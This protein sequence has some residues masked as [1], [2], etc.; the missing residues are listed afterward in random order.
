MREMSVLTQRI[1]GVNSTER[2]RS[3]RIP[4]KMPVL[5]RGEDGVNPFTEE[6]RTASVNAYGRMVRLAAKAVRGQEAATVNPRTVEERPCIV[7]FAGQ[8]ESGKAEV[9]LECIEPSPPFRRMTFPSND[10]DP[11]E[12]KSPSV[13]RAHVLPQS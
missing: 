5:I 8:L 10:W 4:I 1:I 11:S 12:R 2:R 13:A 7:T 3:R 9:G 6:T